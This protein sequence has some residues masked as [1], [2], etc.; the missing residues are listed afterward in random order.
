MIAYQIIS[1]DYGPELKKALERYSGAMISLVATNSI[2]HAF[3]DYL[4]KE[5]LP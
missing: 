1:K 2:S 5:D 4:N 3:V